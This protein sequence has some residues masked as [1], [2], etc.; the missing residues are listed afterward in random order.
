MW[1]RSIRIPILWLKKALRLGKVK[2]LSKAREPSES[3]GKTKQSWMPQS[4]S[5]ANRY[6]CEPGVW[7][8]TLQ[9]DAVD[10]PSLTHLYGRRRNPGVFLC[11][12]DAGNV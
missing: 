4:C 7:I 5:N 9:T 12:G 8:R 10:S 1:A 6:L 11:G 2:Q 3:L